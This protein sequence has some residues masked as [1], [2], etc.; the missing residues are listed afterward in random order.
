MSV[1]INSRRGHHG[2]PER[3]QRDPGE[4]GGVGLQPEEDEE[5]R[6]EQVAQRGQQRPGPVDRQA[7][8]VLLQL[9]EPAGDPRGAEVSARASASS[10]VSWTNSV[11]V[12]GSP[13]S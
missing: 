9:G 3:G 13:R 5:H 10:S 2:Q 12:S 8:D 4:L 7:F 1:L 6:G 11:Q